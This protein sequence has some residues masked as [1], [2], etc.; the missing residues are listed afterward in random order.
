MGSLPKELLG[1]PFRQLI[2]SPCRIF[3]RVEKKVIYIVHALRRWQLVRK[4]LFPTVL[5]ASKSSG[6]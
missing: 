5:R 2:V 4:E 3:Y 1:L 6:D